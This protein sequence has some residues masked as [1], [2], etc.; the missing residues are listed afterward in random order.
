MI[1]WGRAGAIRYGQG[2]YSVERGLKHGFLLAGFFSGRCWAGT[3]N[4]DNLINKIQPLLGMVGS[5]N[6]FLTPPHITGRR[7]NAV[8][9]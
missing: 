3:P 9:H 8:G 1:E 4:P 5:V 7:Q 2:H 6:K